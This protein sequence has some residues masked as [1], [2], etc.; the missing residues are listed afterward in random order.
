[1]VDIQQVQRKI[2]WDLPETLAELKDMMKD[3]EVFKDLVE[4]WGVDLDYEE[5]EREDD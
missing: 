2:S 1:L 4:S 3:N 5:M